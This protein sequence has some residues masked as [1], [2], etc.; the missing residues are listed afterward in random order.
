MEVYRRVLDIDLR[1]QSYEALVEGF[2]GETRAI[3]D[4]I[5]LEWSPN[6]ADFAGRAGDVATPSSS[7]IARGLNIEGVGQWRNYREQLSPVLPVLQPW[8][9]EFGYASGREKKDG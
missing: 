4:F 7:Q 6:M 8:V 5:G 9:E 3:C 2:E 1:D